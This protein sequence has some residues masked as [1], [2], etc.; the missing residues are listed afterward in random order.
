[1]TGLKRVVLLTVSVLAVL[2]PG[3]LPLSGCSSQEGRVLNQGPDIPALD[4][5]APAVTE[6]A[7]F[8]V[9]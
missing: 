9:G 4:T 5:A 8:G 1:M 6:T 3:M 2:G 7:T